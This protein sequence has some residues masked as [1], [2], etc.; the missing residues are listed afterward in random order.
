[1]SRIL[2]IGGSGFIGRHVIAR[3][4]REGHVLRVPTRSRQRAK[5]LI[6]LPTVD[7]VEADV[8]DDP[9]LDQLVAGCDAVINL[10]GLLHS[11]SARRSGNPAMETYG[12]DFARAHVALPRRILDACYKAGVRRLIHF[13]A[14]GAKLDAPSEYL[15]S[16]AAGEEVLIA[17]R[18][19]IDATVLRPSVV[20]GPEDRFLNLFAA[21]TRWFA[22][23][24]VPCPDAR[25]QP[26]YVADVAECVARCLADQ[27]SINHHYDLC[28]PKVYTLRELVKFAGAACGRQRPVIGLPD[29]LA[30]LQA[31]ILECLMI[32]LLTRDN[33]RSMQVP[34]VSD[35]PFPFGMRP[36]SMEIAAPAWLGG[37]A[38]HSH[39]EPHRSRAGR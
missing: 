27:G 30:Y 33:L 10:V 8:H 2:V 37:E 4:A 17:A 28:G 3:L 31:F 13:S 22:V 11:R 12:P 25:F 18:S 20:F 24:L 6:L 38:V 32:K 19:R 7:V 39:Y 5:H 15:R 14:L 23:M 36:E 29:G 34:C 9:T 1:M 21:M 16:K 26:V 35:S